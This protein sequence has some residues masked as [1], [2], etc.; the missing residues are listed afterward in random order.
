ME[1]KLR[2]SGKKYTKKRGERKEI[3]RKIRYIM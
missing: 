1:E 3:K 2:S